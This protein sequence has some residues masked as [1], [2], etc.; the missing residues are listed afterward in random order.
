MK[1]Y[2]EEEE[3]S[4][5]RG[6]AT[7]APST[8]GTISPKQIKT[9]PVISSTRPVIHVLHYAKLEDCMIVVL[10]DGTTQV[11]RLSYHRARLQELLINLQ[12]IY[13]DGHK[14]TAVN[15]AE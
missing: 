11:S 15:L 2:Q 1:G 9:P 3:E 10:S 6:T 5:A 7:T 13:M 4:S 12:R 14:S 8:A